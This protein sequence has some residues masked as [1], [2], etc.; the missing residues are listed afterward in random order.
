MS[1]LNLRKSIIAHCLE[2]NASGLNQGTSGNISARWHNDFLITPTGIPYRDLKPADLPIV[3][4]NGQYNGPLA[5]SSE[6]QFHADILK[7]RPEIN[8]V[9]HAHPIYATALAIN[10]KEIP[11]VHYMIAAAGGNTIRCAQYETYGTQELSRA[12]LIALKDRSACLLANH[13]ILALG[14]TLE[15]AM[16]LAIEVETLARQYTLSLQI[17]SPTVLSEE[18]I[19][20]ILI[21]FKHYGIQS[22]AD[23]N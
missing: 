14:E 7:S 5:P 23:K 17:G 20:R 15:K 21:K 6:W 9:V 22:N 3:Q 13:G 2:M 16:W 12:A 19:E 10:R 4:Y 8:S 1:E 18:E 11:A